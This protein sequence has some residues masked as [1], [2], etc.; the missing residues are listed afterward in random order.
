MV[1][2][3]V[4]HGKS[5]KNLLYGLF[6]DWSTGTRSD[7]RNDLYFILSIGVDFDPQ[8]KI[9]FRPLRNLMRIFPRETIDI[10]CD[11]SNRKFSDFS[12]SC[13]SAQAI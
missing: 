7:L 4:N 10:Y 8:S 11:G 1:N 13:I 12:I 3:V 6:Y 9:Y 2:L 5:E